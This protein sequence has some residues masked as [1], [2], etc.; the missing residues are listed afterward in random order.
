VI[1]W[2]FWGMAA[3][4]FPPALTYGYTELFS[5]ALLL[6]VAV[7]TIPFAI[8]NLVFLARRSPKKLLQVILYAL[9]GGVLFILPYVL[10]G[11]NAVPSYTLA[12]VFALVLALA[13]GVLGYFSVHRS[14]PDFINP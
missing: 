4:A 3:L 8:E 9:G 13:V 7:I 5:S 6:L 10:W 2:L 12:A 14:H 1:Q 11:L